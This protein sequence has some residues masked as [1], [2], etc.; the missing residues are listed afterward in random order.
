[1]SMTLSRTLSTCRKPFFSPCKG[2]VQM[3][4]LVML[5]FS[6]LSREAELLLERTAGGGKS[7]AHVCW[8]RRTDGRTRVFLWRHSIRGRANFV[9]KAGRTMDAAKEPKG[10]SP[11]E[12]NCWFYRGARS[13]VPRIMVQPAYWFTPQ[14]KSK[15]SMVHTTQLPSVRKSNKNLQRFW[16]HGYKDTICCLLVDDRQMVN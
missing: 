13:M 1:M 11:R 16:Y 2:P 10:E 3:N 9:F 6:L 14:R 5:P 12:G 4:W 15:C 8:V 7:V